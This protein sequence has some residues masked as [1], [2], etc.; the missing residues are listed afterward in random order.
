VDA[1]DRADLDAWGIF[2]V[3]AG[4]DDDVRHVPQGYHA[5]L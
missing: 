2:Y 1:I 4:L 3:Y 5:A